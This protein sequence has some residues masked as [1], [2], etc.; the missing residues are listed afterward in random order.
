MIY[1]RVAFATKRSK[2]CVCHNTLLKAHFL[3]GTPTSMSSTSAEDANSERLNTPKSF[4]IPSPSSA[5]IESVTSTSVYTGLNRMHRFIINGTV[6]DSLF[7]VVK[8]GFDRVLKIP[9]IIK[10]SK[11]DR[12]MNQLTHN[13]VCVLDNVQREALMHEHIQELLQQ[14]DCPHIARFVTAFQDAKYHYLI[15]E[16]SIAGDMFNVVTSYENFCL[17]EEEVKVA[18]LDILSAITWLR[19]HEIMHFD[20]SLENFVRDKDNSLKLIDFG[21]AAFH[22]LSTRKLKS[23]SAFPDVVTLMAGVPGNTTVHKYVCAPIASGRRRPGKTQYMSPELFHGSTWDAYSNEIWSFGVILYMMSVGR[24]PFREPSN[25][26]PWYKIISSGRW[27]T[28]A[29]SKQEHAGVYHNLNPVLLQLLD[30]IFKPQAQRL[31]LEQVI[32]HPFFA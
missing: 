19:Q 14:S 26:E 15:T 21:M 30:R 27:L 24:P 31:T 22:P 3:F 23:I 12:A 10:I 32:M 20:L 6:A 29:I 28:P 1:V 2:R 7:G 5:P 11:L 18:A 9:V 16:N 13:G 17:P 8:T 4:C 25:K